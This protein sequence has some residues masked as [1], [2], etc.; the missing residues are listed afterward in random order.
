MGG[1]V[2][3]CD[4]LACGVCGEASRFVPFRIAGGGMGRERSPAYDRHTKHAR[5]CPI[6]TCFDGLSGPVVFR[7][8]IFKI[9]KD[10]LCAVCSPEG[11]YLLIRLEGLVVYALRKRFAKKLRNRHAQVIK[12]CSRPYFFQFYRLHDNEWRNKL[13]RFFGPGPSRNGCKNRGL[14]IK[15]YNTKG[16]SRFVLFIYWI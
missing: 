3:R 10:V 11:Q 8:F 2:G 7:V 15:N 5:P 9:R 14:N 6:T 12:Q 4:R 1:N 13:D 16:I